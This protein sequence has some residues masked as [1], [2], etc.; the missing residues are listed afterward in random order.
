VVNV[1]AS[2]FTGELRIAGSTSN[3]LIVGGSNADIFYGQSGAD[4]LTG[5]GGADQFRL[6]GNNNQVD[7]I[8]DFTQGTDKIGLNQFDFTNTTASQ[9]GTT[10]NTDDYV[11]NRDSITNIGSADADK[12]IELQTSLSSGQIAA[13]T[14]AAV[15]AFVLVFNTTTQKAELWYDNDWSTASNR[16][17]VVTFDNIVELTGVQSFSNVD[18]VEYSF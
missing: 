6:N 17:H 16:D 18:F 8:T 9:A 5:N 15:E 12:V 13:D 10:L 14:G 3:D 4:T 11:D 7:T 2:S 1:D